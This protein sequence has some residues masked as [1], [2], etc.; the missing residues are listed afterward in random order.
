MRMDPGLD[1]RFPKRLVLPNY[2]KHEIAR[3]CEIKAER[4]FNRKFC[5]GLLEALS[6]HI[7]DFHARK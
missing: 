2:T 4:E 6:K 7:G 5:P 3:I 1:R